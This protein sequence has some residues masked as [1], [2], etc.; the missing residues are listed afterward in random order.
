[1]QVTVRLFALARQRVGEPQVV[2]EV[3]PPTT[4]GALRKALA[5]ALPELAPLVPVLLF[6]V[7]AEYAGDDRL[8]APL[9]EVAA[10]P[11]VSGGSSKALLTTAGRAR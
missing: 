7:D 10:I 2:V 11:P 5:A 6:S 9:A 4:V 8:I 1:V 3:P